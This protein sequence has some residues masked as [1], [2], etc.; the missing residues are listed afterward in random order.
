MSAPTLVASRTALP[1]MGAVLAWDGPAL[2]TMPQRK[3]APQRG[4][5]ELGT[6]VVPVAVMEE[7]PQA[8]RNSR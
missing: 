1:P 5:D 4:H 8:C 2:R 3:P 7:S 6:P